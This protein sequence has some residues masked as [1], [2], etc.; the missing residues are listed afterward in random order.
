MVNRVS[1]RRV[2]LSHRVNTIPPTLH[3]HPHTSVSPV[4][5]IP[6]TLHTHPHTSVSPCQYHST[7]APHSPS[8][9]CLTL[10]IP[11]HQRSTLTH[12]FLS[13]PVNTIPPTLHTPPHISI[14]PCQYHSTKAP[15]SPSCTCFS[16]QKDKRKKPG[17]LPESNGRPEIGEQWMEKCL[18][19]VLYLKCYYRTHD[20]TE[21]LQ[22][23]GGEQKMQCDRDAP[24]FREGRKYI[25]GPKM[26]TPDFHTGVL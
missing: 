24:K 20:K 23:S 12:I 3:S 19:F 8:Y 9:F 10:S 17:N 14:S 11:F 5:T 26:N 18:H 7:N 22:R 1:M 4:N 21:A 15:H 6:P 2:F 25:Q 16:Y 13:H